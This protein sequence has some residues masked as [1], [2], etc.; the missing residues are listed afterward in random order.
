[1]FE[2][3]GKWFALLTL[4]VAGKLPLLS[5]IY[6]FVV[7]YLEFKLTASQYVCRS[8]ICCA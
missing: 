6:L 4:S 2:F 7:V 5:V 1:M 8:D 3:L